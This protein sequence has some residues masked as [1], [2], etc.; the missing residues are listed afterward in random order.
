MIL[1]VWRAIGRWEKR[2]KS[3]KKRTKKRGIEVGEQKTIAGSFG[4]AHD[5]RAKRYKVDELLLSSTNQK[6]EYIEDPWVSARAGD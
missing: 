3:E 6:N 4:Q 1:L 5:L 2:K